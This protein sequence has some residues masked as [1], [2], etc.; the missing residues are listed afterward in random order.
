MKGMTMKRI[1]CDAL[2]VAM[3]LAWGSAAMADTLSKDQYRSG[4]D[5]IA[6]THKA[7]KAGCDA[8]SGNAKDV[9]MAQANG[10]EKVAM[11]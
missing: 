1:K 10:N 5:E 6:A 7:A 4:K 11:A 9:C 8:F 2:A 3:A